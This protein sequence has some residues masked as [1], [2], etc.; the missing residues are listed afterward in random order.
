VRLLRL[1]AR[2]FRNLEHIDIEPGPRFTV[3]EG[4][5][6]QGKTALLEAVYV[7]AAL[8]SFRA[9]RTEELIRHGS[10][11]A[12]LHAT[13]EHAGLHRTVDIEL[14]AKRR[15]VRVDGKLARSLSE[16]LGQ[17]TV[18][19]FAP[20]D[21]AITKSGPHHRRRFLD[22]AVFNRFPQSLEVM[23]RYETALKHRNS[24]LKDGA[25]DALLDVFDAQLA[26]A[27]V[28]VLQWRA[29]TLAD[30]VPAFEMAFA[31]VTAGD[32]QARLSYVATTPDDEEDLLRHYAARRRED[33]RRGSTSSGPHVDDLLFHFDARDAR[34]VASQGQHRALVLALKVAEIRALNSA[35]GHSPI[36]LLDD[37]SSEL[38]ARRNADLMRY[39][40]G[41][42]FDGQVLLSTTDRRHI[43]L[44]AADGG[45]DLS[46]A[47][48]TRW[49]RLRAGVLVD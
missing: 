21:L 15:R 46:E 23:K 25:A 8:K 2:D 40:G 37:V 14:G 26:T 32:H 13:V 39:L 7:L 19:L 30:I 4:D 29:R 33:R 17:L 34:V 42:A 45:G 43:Q 31:E 44:T 36:L 22:R 20:E 35:L 24:L 9:Q 3:I 12:T 16:S 47:H 38:D 1:V 27:G 48:A 10:E 11:L 49:F 18:V 6:G 5:N 41:P 28:E